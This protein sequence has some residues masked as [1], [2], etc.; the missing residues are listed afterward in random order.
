MVSIPASI[1]SREMQPSV[2]LPCSL[3]LSLVHDGYA[4]YDILF[5]SSSSS[6]LSCWRRS[7]AHFANSSWLLVAFRS[8]RTFRY[9][10]CSSRCS[11]IC[12]D[13]PTG[14]EV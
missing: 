3:S 6:I 12:A 2:S 10:F 9:D 14:A 8:R 4:V 11:R 1:D 7:F 13:V 5:F